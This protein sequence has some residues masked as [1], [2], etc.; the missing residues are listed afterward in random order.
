[1]NNQATQ[2]LSLLRERNASLANTIAQTWESDNIVT[3]ITKILN[4]K[5]PP[6]FIVSDILT[7]LLAEHAA[8]FQQTYLLSIQRPISEDV[9][10]NNGSG[11][12]L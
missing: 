9:W 4:N 12:V 6:T 10:C 1:M 3:Y 8:Q 5:N 7:R 2:L 11:R